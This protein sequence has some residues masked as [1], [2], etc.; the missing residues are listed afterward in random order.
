MFTKFVVRFLLAIT[1]VISLFVSTPSR[2]S[3]EGTTV[4][5][6]PYFTVYYGYVYINWQPAPN[7]TVIQFQTPRGDIAGEWTVKDPGIL[8]LTML[9]G[10]DEFGTPG[11][12]T[13]ETVI[14]LINDKVAN[15]NGPVIWQNDW[16]IHIVNVFFSEIPAPELIAK[17]AIVNGKPEINISVTNGTGCTFSI[18]TAYQIKLETQNFELNYKSVQW[19]NTYKTHLF[20]ENITEQWVDV[21][22]QQSPYQY[23]YIPLVNR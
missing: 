3:A 2:V 18:G 20:C 11:F 22:I 17:S 5:P 21:K 16:D 15:T 4:Q 12:R 1:F 7:G 9:Y 10:E 19:G 6:T 14:V 23:F 8:A 13:G